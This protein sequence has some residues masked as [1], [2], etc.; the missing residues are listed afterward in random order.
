MRG[1]TLIEMLVALA[2]VSVLATSV[3]LALPDELPAR[4]SESVRAWQRQAQ[5][6]AM[7][8]MG[9][10]RLLAWDI[11]EQRASAEGDGERQ[12]AGGLKV[13][14]VEVEGTLRAL[15]ARIEFSDLP[16]AFVI[17]IAATDRRWELTGLPS[18][19]VDVVRLP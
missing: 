18:G 5:V 4:Q 7:R 17:R 8:A 1:Y 14:S 19:A 15:P 9:E 3:A 10:G 2:I 11:A 6:L 12:L 16:P 13:E